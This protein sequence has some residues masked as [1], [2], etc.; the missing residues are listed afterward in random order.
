M[1]GNNRLLTKAPEGVKL[2]SQEWRES[3]EDSRLR[4][5]GTE[6]SLS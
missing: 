6:N 5:K 3:R 1:A 2:G 4:K